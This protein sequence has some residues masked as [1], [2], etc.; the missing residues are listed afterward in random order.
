[1]YQIKWNVIISF[2]FPIRW[3][4]VPF[5]VFFTTAREEKD[6]EGLKGVFIESW[7]G[8]RWWCNNRETVTKY[9]N[10]LSIYEANKRNTRFCYVINWI[11]VSFSFSRLILWCVCVCVCVCYRNA[12]HHNVNNIGK[13]FAQEGKHFQFPHDYVGRASGRIHGWH[14]NVDCDTIFDVCLC[15]N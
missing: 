15:K 8:Q 10:N 11:W 5:D 1:M 4:C 2:H 6:A 3:N 9:T 14:R 12:T 13:I 7:E